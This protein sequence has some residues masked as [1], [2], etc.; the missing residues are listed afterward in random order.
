VPPRFGLSIPYQMLRD[1]TRHLL[2]RLRGSREVLDAFKETNP[3]TPIAHSPT[4]DELIEAWHW[5]TYALAV[6]VFAAMTVEAA[7]NTY[8]MARFGEQEFERCFRWDGPIGRLRRLAKYGAGVK[9]KKSHELYRAVASLM[10]KRD[11]IVHMQSFEE[12]LDE[13]GQQT[14]P[15]RPQRDLWADADEA[16]R[17]M[18]LFLQRFWELDPDPTIQMMLMPVS[19]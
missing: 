5:Q 16:I 9:L 4:E 19:T 6:Q 7:L 2:R 18:D 17:E 8:G 15:P 14:A 3:P 12:L 1:S 13:Y 10:A 11:S